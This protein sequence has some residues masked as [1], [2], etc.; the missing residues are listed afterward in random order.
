MPGKLAARRRRQTAGTLYFGDNLRILEDFVR[1]ESVDLIYLDPPFNSKR[2]YNITYKGDT[3]QER[4]FDDVWT[5]NQTEDRLLDWLLS[6]DSSGVKMAEVMEALS[7]LL[8]KGDMLSYLVN[9]AVRLQELHR[10][11]KPTG[12]VYLHC[13][14]TA[15]HYLKIMMD[16][17]FG[18]QNFRNEIVWS[19]PA[20]TGSQQKISRTMHDILLFYTKTDEYTFNHCRSTSLTAKSPGTPDAVLMPSGRRKS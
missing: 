16:V 12:S 14:P 19:L 3:A 9:M 18:P 6:R 7:R 4:A 15:S 11:L 13:D 8:E 17:V 1:S 20:W 10:V 2:N 5:W